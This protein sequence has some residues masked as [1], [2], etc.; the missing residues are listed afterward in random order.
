LA[1]PQPL[2]MRAGLPWRRGLL[3]LLS[4]PERIESG[5]WDGEDV[6]RDYYTASDIHGVR[7][8]IFRERTAAHG[9]F[10]H[11]IFG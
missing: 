5:W 4:E 8:W 6:A 11:G 2:A 7:L 9:W 10:L 3:Q 1:V